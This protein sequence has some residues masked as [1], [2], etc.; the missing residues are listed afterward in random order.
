MENSNMSFFR[1]LMPLSSVLF[2]GIFNIF[3]FCTFALL[4]MTD[5]EDVYH[6]FTG[7]LFPMLLLS[8]VPALLFCVPAGLLADRM[9]KRYAIILTGFVEFLIMIAGLC[10]LK[11]GAPAGIWIVFALLFT[12]RAFSSPAFYGILPET[13]PEEEL[14]RANGTITFWQL[15]ALLLGTLTGFV[16]FRNM[17][18]SP[19]KAGLIFMVIS[20]V[21]LFISFRICYTQRETMRSHAQKASRPG[22]WTGL[23][24]VSRNSA[25]FLSALGEHFFLAIGMIIPLLMLLFGHEKFGGDNGAPAMLFFQLAPIFGFGIGSY[26]AGRISHKRI[27]PGLVPFGALGVAVAFFLAVFCPGSSTVFTL[28]IPAAGT[29]DVAIYFGAMFWLL[30]GGIF[31]GFFVIPLRAYTQQRYRTQLRGIAIATANAIGAIML[32]ILFAVILCLQAEPVS[33]LAPVFSSEWLAANVPCVSAEAILLSLTAIIFLV[34]LG[35]MWALPE[36]MLRFVIIAAGTTIYKIRI[37]GAEHIPASGPALLISNH[38]SLADS[39]IISACTSRRIRFFMRDDLLANSGAWLR[40]LARLTRFF[41]VHTGNPKKIA[42]M[43]HEVQDALRAGD[44]VCVF[45]EEVPTANSVMRE[46]K[47][48]FTKMLPKDMPDLPIIPLHIGDM[49]G[50]RFSHFANVAKYKLP[51]RVPHA[52]SV[53]F[54]KPLP[55]DVTPFQVRQIICELAAKTTMENTR[56]NE[57]P[58]HA[59]VAMNARRYP[60]KKIMSDATGPKEGVSY[61][62]VYLGAMLLSRELRSIT[63]PE[64]ERIGILLPNGCGAALAMLATLF[65]DKVPCPLNFTTPQDVY[66]ATLRKSGIKCVITSRKFLPHIRIAEAENMVFLE[67]VAA[68]ITKFKKIA[69]M[70]A[71]SLIPAKELLNLIS[72]LSRSDVNRP[73]VVLFSSGSTGDPKGVELTHHNM[74]SNVHALIDLIGP[75]T[76]TDVFLG[77]LPLFHSFGFNTCFWIPLTARIPVAYVNS[78]LDTDQI[79]RALNREKP[80]I[81]FATPTFLQT[82]MRKCKPEQFESFRLVITGAEKLRPDIVTKF[83]EFTNGKLMITEGY[84]ATELSPVVSVNVPDNFEDLGKVIGKPGSIGP[85]IEDLNVKVVDPITYQELP[86]D[87]EGLLFVRGASVMGGY[88]NDQKKTDAVMIN[89]CY[90]TGDIVTMDSAGHI[91]ICGRLS[92]FSKIAGEMVPHEMVEC[93]INELCNTEMPVVAVGSLPD[94]KKGESLLVIYT[95]EMP[96]TPE[97]VVAELRERSISNLWIPKATNFHP[98]DKLPMLG[99][100]KLDLAALR[101]VADRI[102][103]EQNLN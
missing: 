103:T 38:V 67:E 54:G 100:G 4:S 68:R 82:Y 37:S 83:K 18:D 84:G 5:T 22:I 30:L 49:W 81:L 87:H 91:T 11:A 3:A 80:T 53:T 13:F 66:D 69:G 70:L 56:L 90:N 88:L 98:V 101:A 43:L 29:F 75:N 28:S 63:S 45:P 96:M 41:T 17:P 21:T 1:R 95:P 55:H 72:P 46:F 36:F 94:P 6:S 51:L 76:Q 40:I 7:D 57:L 16:L 48:G 27:E 60:F 8:V 39:I 9:P 62:K 58:I 19:G 77:N 73:A 10:V 44:I 71:V 26:I 33:E 85:A 74:N 35:T 65:A 78:P 52:A 50:S 92:R 79:A 59:R 99:S 2:L 89:G 47:A 15:A 102:A 93:I 42:K 86:P 12:V 31:G 97:E 34:T 23:R 64:E 32:G 20:F 14:S 61:F 25:L 24:E